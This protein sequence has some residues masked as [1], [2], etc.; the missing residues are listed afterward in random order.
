M[1]FARHFCVSTFFPLLDKDRFLESGKWDPSFQNIS[2]FPP[3]L[4]FWTETISWKVESEILLSEQSVGLKRPAHTIDSEEKCSKVYSSSWNCIDYPFRKTWVVYQ[5]VS[6]TFSNVF[7]FSF[8]LKLFLEDW[9]D[10]PPFWNKVALAEEAQQRKTSIDK[11]SSICSCQEE[12]FSILFRNFHLRN[13]TTWFVHEA[14][15]QYMIFLTKHCF[16][17]SPF[18]QDKVI[19]FGKRKTSEIWAPW[20]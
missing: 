10:T 16:P 18:S 12:F 20:T 7:L 6:Q 4:L 14:L 19:H 3:F 17:S 8:D 13:S 2:V 5:N 11:F 9:K 1:L 15:I